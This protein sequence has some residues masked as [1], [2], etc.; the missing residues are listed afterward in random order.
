MFFHVLGISSEMLEYIEE[1]QKYH[2]C[3]FLRCLRLI[4]EKK[5]I[6]I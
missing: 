2:F 5:Y 6:Q 1:N 4:L 3:F